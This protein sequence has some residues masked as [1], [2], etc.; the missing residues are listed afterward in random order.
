MRGTR[1]L[2]NNEIEQCL[3]FLKIRDATLFI[4]GCKTGFRI[5]ELLSLK[6]RDCHNK[7]TVTVRRCNMKAQHS[8][9]TI[10]LH[11]LASEYVNRLVKEKNLQEDDFL[12]QSQKG[13][14]VSRVQAWRVLHDAFAQVNLQGS[15]GT[16]CMRKTFADRVFSLLGENIAKTQ[17]A[18][19]H[20]NIN[21]TISYLSFKQDEIDN[22]INNC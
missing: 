9:R 2:K 4:L 13:G 19:G 22:A 21:S 1:S 3:P 20:A 16:H 18:L 5:S 12:F 8:S 15:L 10:P 14:A 6:V 11:P 7:T 17:K